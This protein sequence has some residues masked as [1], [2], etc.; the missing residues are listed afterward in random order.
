MVLNLFPSN[1]FPKTKIFLYN[2]FYTVATLK[3]KPKFKSTDL[4]N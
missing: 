4:N 3:Y 1:S 2:K